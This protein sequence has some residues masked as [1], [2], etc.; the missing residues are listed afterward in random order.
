MSYIKTI[1]FLPEVDTFVSRLPT[2]GAKFI[3][4]EEELEELDKAWQ[5]EHT[6]IVTLVAWGGVGKTSLVNHW[7]NR[8]EQDK[9]KGAFLLDL[10]QPGECGKETSIH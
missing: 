10:F 6:N 3:G 1:H 8:M 5:D 2:I 4:R 9:Y 7:L